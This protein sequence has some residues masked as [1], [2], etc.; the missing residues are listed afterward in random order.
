MLYV[1]LR[2]SMAAAFSLRYAVE[3]DFELVLKQLY[4]QN[5][6]VG[7]KTSDPNIDDNLLA[8][9]IKL[10]KYPIRIIKCA[11]PEETEIVVERMSS[12]IVS[13]SGAK[14]LLQ[15]LAMC[16]RILSANRTNRIIRVLSILLAVAAIAAFVALRISPNIAPIWI[17]LYQ[18]FWCIP[19]VILSRYTI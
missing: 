4:R 13:R 16:E 3:P 19:V 6:C 8:Q 7:I 9:K 1:A 2:N 17:V 5:V 10:S 18:L 14:A 15:T 12:G 11:Q